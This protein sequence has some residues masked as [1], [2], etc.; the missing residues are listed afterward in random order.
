[1]ASLGCK[2]IVVGA[3]LVSL[4]VVQ[5]GAA[6]GPSQWVWSKSWTEMQF[7]KRFP[8]ATV[9]C[10]AVGPASRVSNYNAYSEFAC[11]VTLARG[12]PYLLVIR[13]RSRAAWTVLSIRKTALPMTAA[14]MGGSGPGSGAGGVYRGTAKVHSIE[15][16]SLD[17]SLL[18]LDDGSR[19]LVNPVGSYTTVL[20]RI[21]DR[22][23]ILKGN[24][25]VY[26][27]QLVDARDN[28]TALARFLGIT[29]P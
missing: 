2:G 10:S 29:G 11:G 5:V 26:R 20:W 24:D 13:P 1:V 14:E 22:L 16:E 27:Y 21:G 19:W 3:M 28:S 4:A 18:V 9:T 25:P 17:G 7:R 8:G 23:V 12:S 15:S 6:A